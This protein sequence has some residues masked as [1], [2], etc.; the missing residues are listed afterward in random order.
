MTTFDIH[1]RHAEASY[2]D[3]FTHAEELREKRN[4]VVLAALKDG[5]TH[6]QV[7]E[8][9]GLTRGRIGQIATSGKEATE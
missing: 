3:A 4:D 1:L 9:T 5:W 2:R 7:A 6:A 8:A